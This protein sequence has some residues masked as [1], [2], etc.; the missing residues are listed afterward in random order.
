MIVA[1][2]SMPTAWMGTALR[3]QWHVAGLVITHKQLW[4]FGKRNTDKKS[5]ES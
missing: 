5:K 3:L 4:T 1:L 2:E